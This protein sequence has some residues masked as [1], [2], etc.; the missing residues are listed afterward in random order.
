MWLT[1][2]HATVNGLMVQRMCK[3]L[4]DTS[5]YLCL[6]KLV[7]QC[8]MFNQATLLLVFT[9][10]A[11]YFSNVSLHHRVS[12]IPVLV[13]AA[14]VVP[15]VQVATVLFVFNVVAMHVSKVSL[16]HRVGSIPELVTA[17]HVGAPSLQCDSAPASPGAQ[18]LPAVQSPKFQ[19]NIYFHFRLPLLALWQ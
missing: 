12:S 11:L 3:V 6:R 9:V 10:V 7:M 4:M 5:M 16:H 13:R 18:S 14:Y 19:H 17:A 2:Q 8:P 1:C 15:D